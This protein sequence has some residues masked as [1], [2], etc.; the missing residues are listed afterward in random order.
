MLEGPV[1]A[2]VIECLRSIKDILIVFSVRSDQSLSI[3]HLLP[4]VPTPLRL[5][6]PASPVYKVY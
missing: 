6:T 1:G 4:L 3:W 5:S 2:A